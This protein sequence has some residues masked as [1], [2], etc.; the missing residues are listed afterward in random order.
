M[1][2][3]MDPCQKRALVAK[4]NLT[5]KTFSVKRIQRGFAKNEVLIMNWYQP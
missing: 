1:E 4:Y 5:S 2:E 3:S